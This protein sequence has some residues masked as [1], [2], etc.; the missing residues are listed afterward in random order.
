[1]KMITKTKIVD[2]STYYY[3]AEKDEKEPCIEI[4]PPISEY[5]HQK[6]KTTIQSADNISTRGT[7]NVLSSEN[8]AEPYDMLTA[9]LAQSFANVSFNIASAMNASAMNNINFQEIISGVKK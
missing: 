8:L 5:E 4:M 6:I 2:G 9:S 1:M 3:R 7:V